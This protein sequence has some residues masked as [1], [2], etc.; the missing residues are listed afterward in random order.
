MANKYIFHGATFN[1]DGTSPDAATV[2]GGVGAWNNINVYQGTAP[3]YGSFAGGDTI[4]VR[5]KD[6]AGAD[7][8]VN[9]ATAMSLGSAAATE[10]API[11]WVFDAGVVWPGVSGTVR[12]N[13]TA[14]IA[15]T[16][17][18]WN[19]IKA[20]NYNFV[21]GNTMVSVTD[22]GALTL[23]T[24][25]TEDVLC[26]FSACT[27]SI[28]PYILHKSGFDVNLW[29]KSDGRYVGLFRP[30]GPKQTRTLFAPQIELLG[31]SE[32]DPVFDLGNGYASEPVTVYGG[33]I[34]GP[35]ATNGTPM[36]VGGGNGNTFRS[37]GLQ[38]PREMPLSTS[39][40]MTERVSGHADGADGGFGS[41]FFSYYYTYTSR[42]DNFPPTLNAYYKLTGGATKY[43]SYRLYPYRTSQANPAQ[44]TVQKTWRQAA[45]A[46]TV[47]QE[48]LW[49][50]SMAAPTKDQV[51]IVVQYTDDATGQLRSLSSRD[52]AGGALE[53]STA[54]WSATTWGVV[55]LNKRK[56]SVTTPTAIKQ[57]TPVLVMLFVAPRSA[58]VNDVMFVCPDPVFSTP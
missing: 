35:G 39:A 9:T 25:W 19:N 36:F 33:R 40:L 20:H 4:N 15:I 30:V 12:Y 52:L 1:G 53:V 3:A 21:V 17:R 13:G 8:T 50:D 47:T 22:V 41:E 42:S 28:G 6:A 49:P 45:A 2:N 37:F 14:R 23:G 55:G 57:D 51:Y 46:Q 43:W 24:G 31:A 27:S 32:T 18:D 56:L 5:T 29:V 11:T 48:L 58:T 7:I 34:F 38:Y 54:A 16:I 10:T 26:D 44:I